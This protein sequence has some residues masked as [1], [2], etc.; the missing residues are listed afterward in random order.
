MM[1]RERDGDVKNP[2]REG[3]FPKV[4]NSRRGLHCMETWVQ[5]VAGI[6]VWAA[7]STAR[8]YLQSKIRANSS[9]TEQ[10]HGE[11]VKARVIG[12]KRK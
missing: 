2:H 6:L 10:Q 4:D 3:L 8:R 7:L 12:G 11:A 1:T 9:Q 5:I